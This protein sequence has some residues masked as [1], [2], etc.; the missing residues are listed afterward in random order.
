[1][2]MNPSD[3]EFGPVARG[4]YLAMLWLIPVVALIF[5]SYFLAYMALLLFL[6]LFLKSIIR[7]SGID[8]FLW[9]LFITVDDKIHAKLIR[10]RIQNIEMKQRD[11]KY[12]RWRRKN[13]KLPR[14]W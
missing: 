6:G 10:K 14:N 2:A 7:K 8:S 9:H 12:R 1:M 11:E 3:F 4:I 13:P 5:S